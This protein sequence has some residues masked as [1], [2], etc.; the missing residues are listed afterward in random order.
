MIARH[1][2]RLATAI[3]PPHRRA[4]GEAMQ[5]EL[6]VIDAP[7]DALTFALGCLWAACSERI[8]LMTLFVSIGRW[9]VGLVTIAYGATYLYFLK[10]LWA[11][12]DDLPYSLP[13]ITA[14]MILSGLSHITAG[15]FLIRWRPRVF[16]WACAACAI[17]A[18]ALIV[19]GLSH[20]TL[21][22]AMP[23]L[24]YGW[25]LVPL[26]MLVIAAAFLWWLGQTPKRPAVA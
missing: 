21:T 8:S 23:L 19:H 13:F 26:A 15:T 2:L 6:D 4:W 1:I 17:P 9:G 16:A 11:A 14:W 24:S 12:R 5:R 3:L 20:H 25:Q 18:A 22:S 10:G 7:R